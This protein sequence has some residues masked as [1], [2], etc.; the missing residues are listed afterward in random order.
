[1]KI[2]NL[3]RRGVKP[4]L[5]LLIGCVVFLVLGVLSLPSIVGSAWGKSQV[6]GLVSSI[7][8]RQMEC[9]GE[10]SLALGRSVSFTA[11][12]L[13]LLQPAG[14]PE[15]EMLS[16]GRVELVIPLITTLF[17]HPTF[18][19]IV[20]ENVEV[21]IDSGQDSQNAESNW[22]F[23]E[24]KSKG[25]SP[26]LVEEGEAA[27]IT[28]PLIKSAAV[29]SLSV[30]VN[31]SGKTTR[32]ALEQLAIQDDRSGIEAGAPQGDGLQ[33]SGS[34]VLDG[35]PLEV[36][37]KVGSVS[38]LL[39]GEFTQVEFDVHSARHTVKAK[40]QVNI[41]GALDLDASASGD[42]FN[43][44]ASPLL[45]GLPGWSPYSIS[46]HA[47]S[48]K[49]LSYT[50]SSIT[51][52]LGRVDLTG[53]V[54]LEKAGKAPIDLRAKIELP[55]I[56]PK[57]NGINAS[58]LKVAGRMYKGGQVDLT[59]KGDVPDL[60]ELNDLFLTLLP[61]ITSLSID[62]D[63]SFVPST[64][65]KRDSVQVRKLL[66]SVAD[67]EVDGAGEVQLQP[68]AIK[69]NLS[70]KRINYAALTDLLAGY[71]SEKA[72]AAT[73]TSATIK[74]AQEPKKSGDL[75]PFDTFLGMHLDVELSLQEVVGLVSQSIHEIRSRVQI[76][77]GALTL[78]GLHGKACN[79]TVTGDL[80]L[81]MNGS[82]A[83][84]KIVDLDAN[85]LSH[86][87]DQKPVVDGKFSL[88]TDVTASGRAFE[89][90][91]ASLSGTVE[92]ASEHADFKSQAVSLSTSGL[93]R[94]LSPLFK[95]GPTTPS[96]CILINFIIKDGV[97][98]SNGNIVNLGG[99]FLFGH[100]ELNFIKN[101]IAYSCN[102]NST[103]PSLASLIPP[104]RAVGT[105]SNP[106]FIP[107]TSGTVASVFDSAE[108]VFDSAV[109]VV[110]STARFILSA[111]GEKFEGTAL[112]KK[113]LEVESS[114]MSSRVGSFLS[115]EES[116]R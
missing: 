57:E 84:L 91:L 111:P 109:G 83:K 112:C 1:M 56:R 63:A 26:V 61:K 80:V 55:R 25:E 107:S 70:S 39:A 36:K 30:I 62:A 8:E 34:G 105:L 67:S 2:V 16:V 21:R 6:C 29:K 37:G 86:A 28:I 11:S 100:G 9:R 27:P 114:R 71:S 102:V 98:R 101:T 14:F 99:V 75:L 65:D 32:Y 93:Q 104:F 64:R 76:S 24:S 15:G 47:H 94:I 13:H 110:T 95:K 77:D 115:S 35:L 116:A 54:T 60:T 96:D 73:L 49:P 113:A 3:L 52:K 23:G 5:F 40:G 33:L 103:N 72:K 17:T 31:S 10:L 46:F 53:E 42:T 81:G 106:L 108:G 45:S 90:M 88:T 87:F 97:A 85:Q 41:E 66:V 48:P 68:L 59:V 43:T 79:G 82:S 78:A 51:S 18:D 44:F 20:V 22:S 50:F 4:L 7:L 74:P 12:D 38:N 89:S 58:G 69:G 19:S 92:I